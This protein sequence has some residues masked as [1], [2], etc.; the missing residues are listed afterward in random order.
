MSIEPTVS[1][2]EVKKVKKII[3]KKKILVDESIQGTNDSS[4]VSKRSVERLYRK[5]G[6]SNEQ[7]MEFF[8]Y[9]V[10]KPQRRSP[11][12]NRGYWTRIEAMKSVISKVLVQ[13]Q[14]S[15]TK[16]IVVNLGCGFDPYPFQYLSS[17]EN[18]ENVTFLDVDYSDLIFK[19]AAT[20]Y[21]TKELAQII[22]PATYSPNIDNDKNSPNGKIYLQAE[23]YIALGCDLRE[24]NTFEAALRDLFDLE[25]SVVLFTAEVSLTYMIQKTADDLIRWAA[26]LPRAEF[27]LLEQIMPA[28]EDH[29]FAKTML[30][31]FNSLKTPLHSITSYPNIGKQRDRFLSRGWKSVN[32]QNLFDFWTNDVSDADKKFV[33]SVEE[34]DEWEEFI[35]FGQHYFIL[36]ATGGSQVKLAPSIDNSDSTN[37]EL[38]SEVSIS[39][40]SLP[41]AKRKF[42]AGCTHGSSIFFHG[43]VTTARESS[44]LI[45][46]ANAN[47]SYPYDECPIQGRTCHTL[48]NLTNGDILLVGGRLRPANPLADC[49]LLTKETGEWSRV[50]DLPSPRS[51]HCAVNIDD[52]ILIFGGSGRE[53][54]SPFLSWSQELGWRYV[55][56]KGCPIPNLFSPAMCNTSNNGIIVGGMD[57]DKKVRSEV[58]SFIYD[59]VTNTVTVELVPVR[60]QALVTRYGSRSTIIGNS[61]VLIF[62]GVSSQ[63]LLDRHD[64]FVSLNYKTGEIKRHPIT[65]NHELPMLVGFCAN[66]V[67]LGQD[68]HILSYG[69]GCVCFSFGSFWDDVYS[70]GLGN[71]ASLPELATI[72]LSGSAKDNE[73][74]DGLDHG[75]VSVKEVPIIDV[76][77]NPVS[78]E[79]FR[80]I[81]RL[82][83]PV[84]FRNSH[85]GPCIDSWRSP[86]YLVEKVGHDTKVVAHVTSSDALNFQAK[87]FDYKSLDFKDFVTKMFSTSEKVYLRSLSI[88]DPKSKP[89]IF[90]SDFPGLSNDFKLPDFLDSLEKD[91]FSSPLRLSSANTSMWLHYDVT[92]NVLCQVVGQKRVRLYPPQDVVHLSFPAG[93]SS[94]T[95]EN[96]FANP[97]PAHYKCHPMEVVMHPGDIIFIPSMWLHATQPLV[98]SVSLNFFWKDLEPSIYAAG[99]DVYGNRDI[100]A[101]DDGRKA[102]LKLVNS[103]HDVPQEIRKFYLLR[104]ADEIRKQ[105]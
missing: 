98:A 22:G 26:G 97:P 81:C 91:H 25:N 55:E 27:A 23:K 75:D 82:R 96:I 54:P 2:P 35:L 43:G 101:Y 80:T 68:K 38:G 87:N 12:I 104:L 11:I 45:I 17:G 94:S 76:I 37:S 78:Q 67:N 44:S 49:W 15:E 70:F 53:E 99:K 47:D 24:L 5:K 61:T 57:D 34:F 33:E 59:R 39:R 71:A 84:L 8:R 90:K 89:A 4:I 102:V 6:S 103:F 62:G 20:V 73:Q 16:V 48:S 30:K 93:A 52:Q 74:Y 7:P 86:E 63:K 77:T 58:Y 105:C 9:F 92:A 85:L 31:H 51:R 50:E 72:K 65:S 40:V 19:K 95:I 18:C 69:G 3:K 21:R 79:S 64:I 56:V 100:T 29:P 36:H 1:K 88:S 46:S 32:V 42:L 83:S 41:K 14:N 28:G 66:E 10:P 60:E 13:Y